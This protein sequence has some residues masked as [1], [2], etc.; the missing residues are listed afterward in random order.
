VAPG[1]G[2]RVRFFGVSTVLVE[3]GATGIM[4]DGF[5]SRPG[6]VPVVLLKVAP[7]PARIDAALKKGNVSR[8]AAV[9]VAHSHY[10]HALDAPAVAARTGAALIGSESTANI[11]RG[12][13]LPNDRIRVVRDGDVLS[14]GA[15]TVRVFES[16]H[17]PNALFPGVIPEPL[18]TPANAGDFKEGG[19]HSFLVKHARGTIL[20][21]PSAN[22]LPG[23]FRGLHADVV[24]LGIGLLGKQ[25]E[26]FARDYWR[27]VVQTT[28]PRLVIPIHWDDFLRPLDEPLRPMPYLMDD[29]ERCM[30]MLTQMAEA[31][32]ISLR[33]LPVFQPFDPF[34]PAN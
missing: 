16:P 5:F 34:A 21:H 29:F 11:G 30:R 33:F 6:F 9:L 27:E 1:S 19:N 32:G 18:R 15:F 22:F 4:T 2:V 26:Q 25:T 7:D 12:Q 14:F 28:R 24:F 20:V 31:D 10:D 8:L 17:S 23:M 13:G 3:D